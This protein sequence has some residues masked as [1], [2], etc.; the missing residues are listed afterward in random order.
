MRQ[1]TPINILDDL[2]PL[3]NGAAAIRQALLWD[4]DQLGADADAVRQHA[5]EI[6]L[7]ERR[8]NDAVID[9]GRHLI[10]V[11]ERLQ[12]GQ[13]EDWL[14]TEFS[15]TDRTARTLMSIA[16][17]FD[18]KTEIISDLSVTVLGL[19]ASPSVPDAAVDAVIDASASGKVTV[20]QAKAVIK[21]HKPPKIRQLTYGALLAHIEMLATTV[22]LWEADQEW[23]I[24]YIEDKLKR[25]NMSAA[26]LDIGSA[27]METRDELAK[28]SIREQRLAA[29]RA[30]AEAAEAALP[31]M[32]ADLS[33]PLKPAP[34]DRVG[35]MTW[36][37]AEYQATI[38]TF[39]EYGELLGAYLETLAAKRELEKLIKHLERECALLKGCPEPDA[40]MIEEA[41]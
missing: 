19:L 14:K 12:H 17:R 39:D 32:P 8:A 33:T 5:V 6:K 18:G 41:V 13:W 10:A 15:M 31:P 2:M 16:E 4:Y 36:L 30:A 22:D 20:A 37:I 27:I 28:Q 11:K 24:C 21:Q 7:S 40:W 29:A 34:D 25:Q 1:P 26:G 35:K 38:A 9:A 3:G 23:L